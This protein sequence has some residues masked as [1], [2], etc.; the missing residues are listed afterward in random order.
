MIVNCLIRR[1]DV[2]L[3]Y[4]LKIDFDFNFQQFISVN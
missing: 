2:Y 1:V 4:E 3:D